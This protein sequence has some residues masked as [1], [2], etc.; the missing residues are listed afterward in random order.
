[1]IKINHL[2][3]A[4]RVFSA[5]TRGVGSE[6]IEVEVDIGRGLS[7]F[8]IVGLADTSV[9]EA[10]E[11]IRFA[12]KNCGFEFSEQ[13]K[14]I[15]LAPAQ[16]QKHG[17][18]F[19]LAMAIGL[20][21][22]SNQIDKNLVQDCIFIGEICLDGSIRFCKGVLPMVFM[23]KNKGFKRV[24]V[25]KENL[26]E[27]LLIKGIA[28]YG[29]E[30][31]KETVEKIYDQNGSQAEYGSDFLSEEKDCFIDLSDIKGHMQAKRALIIA[32]AGGHNILLCGPPG[33]GKTLL[34]NRLKQLLPKLSLEDS[35]EVTCVHS[36]AGKLN[37][38]TP[39]LTESPFEKIHHSSSM[40][41]LIGGG[42]NPK[43]GAI[44]L[45]HKG[46]LLLDEIAEFP[47]NTLDSLRQPLEDREVVIGRSKGNVKFPSNFLL[48][49]TM[50][51]CPCGFAM[52]GGC[53]CSKMEVERYQKKISG[54]LL[55]RIDLIVF[56]RKL[57]PEEL[58]EKKEEQLFSKK[59]IGEIRRKQIERQGKLNCEM[60]HREIKKYCKFSKET[61][62]MLISYVEKNNLSARSFIRI[63]RI[64]RTISDL[65]NKDDISESELLEAMQYKSLAN[66]G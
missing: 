53:K 27:A 18:S 16:M 37:S 9:Q 64:A 10:K 39:L 38:K 25:P 41:S 43:P 51:P 15:N 28:I 32:A 35:I 26:N 14:V 17:S 23:A 4:I 30:T 54:P 55:D 11:R 19:D 29:I 59:E 60:D 12:L 5:F 42:S 44:S 46:V 20:L 6:L 63:Q 47:K 56:L 58:G 13:R 65:K 45:A 8:I 21:V 52:E 40:S 36:V 1:M 7:N 66:W 50:N 22:A 34:A 62:A 61:E 48:A 57:K 49:A 31:L 33:C 3:M 2:K 24:F